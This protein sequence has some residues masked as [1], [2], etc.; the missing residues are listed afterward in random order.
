MK[1]YPDAIKENKVPQNIDWETDGGDQTQHQS[2]LAEPSILLRL[3]ACRG[4]R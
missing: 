1:P 2:T 4:L 3:A